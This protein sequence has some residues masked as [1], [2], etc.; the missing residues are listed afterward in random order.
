MMVQCIVKHVFSLVKVAL[1]ILFVLVVLLNLTDL[2]IHRTV[3]VMM[4]IFKIM[5]YNVYNVIINVDHVK[6]LVIIA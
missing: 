2:T 3:V 6:K 1:Q 5:I 4:D